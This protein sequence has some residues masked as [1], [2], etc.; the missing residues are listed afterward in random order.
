MK[1]TTVAAIIVVSLAM[2]GQ[3]SAG[4][5]SGNDLYAKCTAPA[6][7]AACAGYVEG[8]LDAGEGEATAAEFLQVQQGAKVQPGAT[9]LIKGTLL[10]FHWCL[11]DRVTAGQAIDVVTAF[12][13]NNPALRDGLAPGLVAM[14]LQQAWPCSL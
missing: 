12:L 10:G 7:F 11:R 3:A 4:F 1:L 13:R 14:A 6:S 8:I 9:G 5:F 2:T